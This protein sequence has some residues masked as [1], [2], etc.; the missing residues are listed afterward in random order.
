[1]LRADPEM[2]TL[3]DYLRRPHRVAGHG[4]HGQGD[5]RNG[6]R[7]EDL[8]LSVPAG[9]V[10]RQPDGTVVADLVDLDQRL[11]AAEGGRAAEAMPP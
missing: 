6:K 3:L 1:M 7:G 5:N 4:V 8:V 9:T 10:V 11:V 2:G